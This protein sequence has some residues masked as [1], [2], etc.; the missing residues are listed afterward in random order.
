MIL[1]IAPEA[2]WYVHAAADTALVL[3]IGGGGLSIAA[4]WTSILARKG[5]RLHRAAGTVFFA[6]MLSMAGVAA[7]VAPMLPEAQWTNTTAAIF[8]LYLVAT[9]WMTVRRPAGEVGR[10]EAVALAVP[11]GLV[12]LSLGV[13]ALGRVSVDFATVFAF[14][15]IAALAG[16]CD[17]RMLRNRG[18]AGPARV[19]R[20]LWRMTL[21]LFVA[22]GSF[23]IGQ[24]DHV[25]QILKDTGLNVAVSVAV[26]ALLAFWMIRTR[27][28]FPRRRPPAAAALS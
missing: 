23:F 15:A 6:A 5:G 26:L 10:F 22:T 20:H 21:G 19:A 11:A 12:L 9:A 4:G 2:P 14:S 16:V 8:T 27:V 13:I 25:P 1:Q 28:R 24:P 3:H 17:L 7:I 18:I